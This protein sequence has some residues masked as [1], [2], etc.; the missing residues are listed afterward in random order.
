MTKYFFNIIYFLYINF[1]RLEKT[2]S[3]KGQEITPVPFVTYAALR[4][5]GIFFTASTIFEPT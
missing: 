3:K 1:D 4:I 5:C 2:D